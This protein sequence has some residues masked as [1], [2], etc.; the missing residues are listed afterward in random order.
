MIFACLLQLTG[1][2]KINGV[3]YIELLYNNI[4]GRASYGVSV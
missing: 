4:L 2:N 1:Y 3:T